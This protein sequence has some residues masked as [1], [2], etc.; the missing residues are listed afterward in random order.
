MKFTRRYIKPTKKDLCYVLR[1][2]GGW[3]DCVVGKPTDKECRC[4]SNCVGYASGRFN[5]IYNELTDKIGCNFPYLNCNA[6]NFIERVNKKY[7]SLI[8]SQTPKPGSIMVWAKGEVGVSEDGAGHVAIVEDILEVNSTGEPVSIKTSESSYNGEAF[9]NKIRNKG[10]DGRWGMS[11]KYTFR[12]FIL[13]PIEETDEIEL[14]TSLKSRD[15]LK[16]Q[17]Y[18]GPIKLRMRDMSSTKGNMIGICDR[19]SF[20][21]VISV[22]KKSDY[23][24]YQLSSKVY[25]AGVSGVSYYPSKHSTKKLTSIT[26]LFTSIRNALKK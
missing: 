21:D 14:P 7:P 20:Y 23:T 26:T 17:I 25:V 24:W 9:F 19:C 2:D 15:I 22:C 4:L 10:S 12:G 13:C 18:V 8:I 5:E 16:N 11:S 6:E 1:S 3:N